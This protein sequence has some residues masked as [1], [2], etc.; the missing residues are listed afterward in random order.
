M[1]DREKKK[2][3]IVEDEPDVSSYLCTFLE[4]HGFETVTAENG[5]EGYKKV[6]S[7][8]PDLVTL[9]ITMPEESGIRMFREMQEDKALAKI[10]V[11]IVTG[12][13]R[14]FERFI[15]NRKQVRP[16][17]GYFEKPIDKEEFLAAIHKLLH[18]EPANG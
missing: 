4:D 15:S 13:S 8:K 3:L 5:K 9:D 17:D 10:P 11:I 6:Q 14:E 16:P 1:P 2:I 7:E 18:L 12:V